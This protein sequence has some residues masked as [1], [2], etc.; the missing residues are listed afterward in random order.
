MYVETAG[1]EIQASPAS[2][3][4]GAM[5]VPSTVSHHMYARLEGLARLQK[6]SSRGRYPL[7]HKVTFRLSLDE[8]LNFGQ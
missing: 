8:S 2:T 6:L 4:P 5:P 1:L 7:T 3:G